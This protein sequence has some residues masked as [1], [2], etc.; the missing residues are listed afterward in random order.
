MAG[1]QS[2]RSS[3]NRIPIAE[4]RKALKERL[5]E[6]AEGETSLSRRVEEGQVHAAKD[7]CVVRVGEGSDTGDEPRDRTGSQHQ[8]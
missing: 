1:S 2:F 3:G 4:L 5:G 6:S 8:N 7:P